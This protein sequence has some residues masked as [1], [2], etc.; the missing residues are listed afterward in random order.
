MSDPFKDM[1]FKSFDEMG[2]KPAGKAAPSD[3]SYDENGAIQTLQDL[4]RGGAQGAT[5]SFADELTGAGEAGL[6]VLKDPTKLKQM[7]ELYEQHRDE[8]RQNFKAARERS[9]YATFAGEMLGGL[10]VPGIGAA[11]AGLTGA[12]TVGQAALQGAKVGAAGG[13]LYGA[14]SSE[15]D[16]LSG[17]FVQDVA[18]GGVIGG[19]LGG[20]TQAF[21]PGVKALGKKMKDADLAPEIV[22]NMADAFAIEKG[23]TKIVGK[24]AR[25]ELEKRLVNDGDDVLK[26]LNDEVARGRGIK[27]EAI[28]TADDAGLKLNVKDILAKYEQEALLLPE[29]RTD[30]KKEKEEILRLIRNELY[31]PEVNKE[32][33]TAGARVIPGETIPSGEEVAMEALRKRMASLNV[34]NELDDPLKVAEAKLREKSAQKE[35][36]FNS[37]ENPTVPFGSPSQETAS[38]GVKGLKVDGPDGAP[39]AQLIK[40]VKPEKIEIKLDEA[41]GKKVAVLLDDNGAV[42]ATQPVSEEAARSIVK[43]IPKETKTVTERVGGTGE[44]MPSE[45]KQLV[46]D[47]K[48]LTSLGE[49]PV[50]GPEA[51]RVV[52][53]MTKEL[54]DTMR[55]S[56]MG[57]LGDNVK[58]GDKIMS[59]VLDAEEILFPAL[60]GLDKAS[61]ARAEKSFSLMIADLQKEGKGGFSAR[62]LVDKAMERIAETNPELAKKLQTRLTDSATSYDLARQ[63]GAE[64]QIQGSVIGTV[65]G[66]IIGA[67]GLAGRASRSLNNIPKTMKSFISG[68]SPDSLRMTK[69]ALEQTGKAPKDLINKLTTAEEAGSSYLRNSILFGIMQNPEY[70][71]LIGITDKG[72]D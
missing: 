2:F 63:I 38:S 40:E 41:T 58:E 10:A 26:E 57:K 14:G 17:D 16:V 24:K 11:K 69:E 61:K 56:A 54:R 46:S 30:Q 59:A 5:F 33:V 50:K 65:Q 37:D 4:L 45:L 9:P 29:R 19:A 42:L 48:G 35:L 47:M 13:A 39:I 6:D 31:G 60:K 44:F 22:E 32:V 52:N 12:K 28:K 49:T 3:E 72:E 8:S 36:T 1:G 7:L 34:K 70:R 68:S 15:A 18:T 67:A 71:A 27:S 21:I 62:I 23:G 53:G 51:S 25:R 43:I 55:G 66:K 20:A 64:S